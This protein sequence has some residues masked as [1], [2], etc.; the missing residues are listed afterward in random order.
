MFTTKREKKHK[1]SHYDVLLVGAGLYNAVIANRC[2]KDGKSVLVI[3]RRSHIAGNCYTERREN[4]DV[5]KYGAH[6]FHTDDKKVWD[7]VNSF[8]EFNNFINSPIAIYKD[9]VYNMPFNMNTFNRLYG[10]I[11]PDQAKNVI[12]KESIKQQTADPKNLEDCAIN[13][14]GKTMYEKLIKGYTEKQWG[15]SCNEL[16]AYIIKRLPLRYTYDNNYFNDKYQGIPVD[17]YT[18][19]IERM[20]EGAEIILNEDYLIDK[21]YYNM[22]AD[23]IYY[24]GCIDEYYNYIYG[25]LEYRSIEL[26]E[27]TFN[28][29]NYQGNAVVNYTSTEEPYTRIIE[30]KHFNNMGSEK[31][32]ISEEYSLTWKKGNEPYY[33]ITDDKNIEIYNKYK[34]IKND[35]VKFVGRLGLYRYMDMDDIISEAMKDDW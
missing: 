22:L 24:S 35:K 34:S 4:I 7:F 31:T 29:E 1:R 2:I 11:T 21:E 30:H 18:S 28:K 25:Y 27:K 3:D 10:V 6:I 5:H 17:G 13:L 12:I 9:E 16:P 32:I 33:P 8:G 15:R 19:I 20:Y 23:K 14:V 26:K